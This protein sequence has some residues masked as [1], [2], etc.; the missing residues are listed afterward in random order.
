MLEVL[1]SAQNFAF[2]DH[3]I[4]VPYDLSKVMFLTTANDRSAIP[5][6]LLDR[7]EVIEVPG[8]LETEK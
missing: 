2:R 7:M 3:F 1:D 5:A 4:E 8:Y 6:P